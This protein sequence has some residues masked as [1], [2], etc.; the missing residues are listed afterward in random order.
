M[1]L[2]NLIF[3]D[4]KNIT[5]SLQIYFVIM[6]NILKIE[7][8]NVLINLKNSTIK[9]IFISE[10]NISDDFSTNIHSLKWLYSVVIDE[11]S[12]S[13]F[14][15]NTI[16]KMQDDISDNINSEF[17]V[18]QIIICDTITMKEDFK[19]EMLNFINII[20]VTIKKC[21]QFS[22]KHWKYFQTFFMLSKKKM[23]K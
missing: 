15:E 5:D 18:D 21:K 1:Y 16:N 19:Q 8:K 13:D 7:Q 14:S 6:K 20:H 11:N 3:S 2:E 22:E 23:M 10:F 9:L 17:Y 4:R 12:I